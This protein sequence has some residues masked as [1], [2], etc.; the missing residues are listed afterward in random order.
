MFQ[1]VH[2]NTSKGTGK[3]PLLKL[4]VK[5]DLPISNGEVNAKKLD[6][7]IQ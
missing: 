4:D 1:Y 3:S 7:W 6:N 5:F 2:P